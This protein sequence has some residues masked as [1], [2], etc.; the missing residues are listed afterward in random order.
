MKVS[1][2]GKDGEPGNNFMDN[3]LKNRELVSALA[4]GRLWGEAFDC[5]VEASVNDADAR[6]TW[7]AYHLVGDALR[8]PDLAHCCA[9]AGF[10]TRLQA[11]LQE[12]TC[13]LPQPEM[14][15]AVA[16]SAI[17]TVVRS[18][19][20]DEAANQS[21]FRWKLVA[22]F[23]SMA[24]VATVGWNLLGALNPHM[25]QILASTQ[26]VPVLTALVSPDTAVGSIAANQVPQVMIRDAHLDALLA[27][28]KQFGG[29][30]A[31]QAPSGFLRNATF[32]VAGH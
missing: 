5:A 15:T 8:S 4:D 10:M 9:S 13:H 3:I 32:E 21:V 2:D 24:A 18:V 20:V 23:A 27:A 16:V 12:E 6:A 19:K 30:S 11:R 14:A 31:L 28:H 1:N 29:A 26:P 17:A 25:G 22:G 7:H